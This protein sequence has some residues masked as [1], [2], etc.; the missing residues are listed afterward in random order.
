MQPITEAE[1]LQLLPEDESSFIRN[2]VL[3]ASGISDAPLAYHYG[4]ALT[5][6][7]AVAP[8]DLVIDHLPGGRVYSNIWV[9]V[10]G[11]PAVDH[12][13][14]AVS[15]GEGLLRDAAPRRV[16]ST[17]DSIE[18]LHDSLGP[19]PIQLF[20]MG[21]LGDLLG[22]ADGGGHSI[23]IKPGLLALYDC[24]AIDKKLTRKRIKVPNPRVSI[25]GGVNPALVERH[26]DITDWEGGFMSRFMVLWAHRERELYEVEPDQTMRG[27]LVDW[28]A[29]QSQRNVG[30]CVGLEPAARSLWV[31]WCR[32][33]D[34]RLTDLSNLGK[35]ASHGRTHTQAAKMAL[36]NAYD[37]GPA[38]DGEPWLLDE[39]VLSVS[40]K[41]AELH[42]R[43]A[44]TL[45]T[46]AFPSKDMRDRGSVLRAIGKQWRPYGSILRDACLLRM[47]ADQVVETL[48][49]EG[50]IEATNV[51]GRTH[52]RLSQGEADSQRAE[53]EDVQRLL[54]AAQDFGKGIEA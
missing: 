19:E 51:N 31:S 11:R 48:L 41:A 26:A 38:R 17:P 27:F 12:K 46:M 29:V 7:A 36:L 14:T 42:Y 21:E 53:M 44:L 45:A 34:R 24:G 37:W 20:I 40:I 35:T 25:L 13:T 39:Q 33:M 49:E 18:G 50:A 47:R 16:S 5:L 28:L 22:R 2:Y 15:I 32:D 1:V 4:T 30:P 43:S 54:D 10:T 52:Y 9:M 8:P 23:K 6:L 3:Y